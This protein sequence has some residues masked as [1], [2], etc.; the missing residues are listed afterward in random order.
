M[1]VA[2]EAAPLGGLSRALAQALGEPVVPLGTGEDRDAA[3]AG[4][5]VHLSLDA[6]LVGPWGGAPD[7][8]CGECLAI[9]WQ[10]LRLP[11]TR[12]ALELGSGTRSAGPWPPDT[13]FVADA[14]RSVLA[15]TAHASARRTAQVTR[16]DLETLRV[17]TVPLL[18]EPLCPGHA[19]AEA[20]D[21]HLVPRPTEGA[22]RLRAAGSYD[23]PERALANPVCGALGTGI[24]EDLFAPLTAAVSGHY[25]ERAGNGLHDI[26]WSGKAG[27]FAASRSLAL[28]EGLERYAGTRPRGHAQL[29]EDSWENLG[30]VA[31]DPRLCGEYP[32]Q[33]YDR[34]P[35][36]RRFSPTDRIPWVWGRSLRDDRP[37][38]VPARTAY[39]S[40]DLSSALS[41]AQDADAFVYE[42]SNGCATGSCLE[43]AVLFGLLELVER[44]AFLLGWYSRAPATEIDLATVPG[45]R[46]LLDRAALHGY[47]V[48]VFDSRV[49]L[50]VPVVTALAERRD[51][52]LGTLAFAAA[53]ALDPGRA[54][55]AA[56][57]E[58]LTYLPHLGH[59]AR[60]RR[61]ELELM[62]TDFDR[63][64]ELRDHALLFA[65]PESAVHAAHYL[66]PA[67]SVSFSEAYP[68]RPAPVDLLGEVER[69]V[70]MLADAGCDVI[71]VDQT[72][73]EQAAAG[74]RT[75]RAIAPGLVPIDFGWQRQRAL[76]MPRLRTAHH[77]AGLLP[78]PLTDADLHRVPHP[79]P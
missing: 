5:R 43:E 4:A 37:I 13:A 26:A 40:L 7:G 56:L 54:V 42:C 59:Q 34:D 74:L 63:V 79:F 19:H 30:D 12:D 68:K 66:S 52:A 10:R 38:L 3:R 14:V 60:L 39:Y 48:R 76:T 62:A 11:S 67:R 53:A 15:A 27:S 9:R 20:P 75:V 73:P 57:D 23:L 65:L 78:A 64:V 8:P 1:T 17:E 33:T 47:G 72:T 70:G 36:L 58:A 29:I 21:V 41:S 61:R 28:L 46:P 55:T 77:R 22:A 32:A 35:T 45:V 50:D 31:L 69:L 24:G 51:G 49:D 25:L 44:D 16:L 2:L 71:V 6:V 18:G